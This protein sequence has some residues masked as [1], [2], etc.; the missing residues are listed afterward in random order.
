[1][2]ILLIDDNADDLADLRQM[3]LQSGRHQLVFSTAHTGTEGIAKVFEPEHGPVDCVLLDFS[4]PDMDAVQVLVD[5][6]QGTD[7]PPCPI[8]VVTGTTVEEGRRLLKSGAQDFIGKHWASAESLTRAVENAIE[9]FAMQ[10]ER[11]NA[12]Q[13]A[14]ASECRY[15]SLFNS[16]D[17]GYCVIEMLFD[18]AGTA[19]DA[20]YL[21]VNLAFEQQS[22]LVD[23][24]NKTVR[25]VAPHIEQVWL[26]DYGT[27]ALTG[28]SIRLER[29][30]E[31]SQRW[32]DI[33]AFRI[34]N[35]AA[36]QVA[37]LFTDSTQRK[38]NET[39]LINSTAQSDAAN[40][41]KSE[42]LLRM[43]HELRSPLSV[44]LGFAQLIESGNPAPTATQLKNV[45]QI[46]HA[47]WY[48]LGLVNEILDLSAIESGEI[49]ISLQEVSLNEVLDECVGMIQLQALEKNVELRFPPLAQSWVVQADQV[50]LK[51]VLLNLLT[52]AIKYN[53]NPGLIEVL[54]T[55]TS[56]FVKVSVND[57]GH[58]LSEAQ[59]AQLFQSFNRLGKAAS[60]EQGTGVGLVI[61]KRLIELMHGRIGVESEVGVGSRFWFE[62]GMQLP[63]VDADVVVA[64]AVN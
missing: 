48:L 61:S 36:R 10:V 59:M 37:I 31:S 30:A 2:H 12:L 25:E 15:R 14:R 53:R 55:A 47:G 34:S 56:D 64:V 42:F 18:E 7:M 24:L 28:V 43:S 4:L 51:Q 46:L 5:L 33:S 41:A 44:M 49:V 39:L 63:L 54:C 8:V 23:V 6:C 17:P 13:A 40:R 52:N 22:G 21:E 1:M 19:I 27:V 20:R 9:R 50:R 58:G 32:F 60:A 57:T 35:P 29:Y 26:D 3:L 45:K 11:R 16:I 38:Q 62:L